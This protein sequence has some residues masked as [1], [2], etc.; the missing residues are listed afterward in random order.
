MLGFFCLDCAGCQTA[1]VSGGLPNFPDNPL[2]DFA[3]SPPPPLF[4]AQHLTKHYGDTDVV[5]DLSFEIAS[6]ECLGVVGPNG[7]GKT[8]TI[9]MCLGLTVPDA[10]S[11][12]A[13]ALSMPLDAPA[14]KAQLGVVT[15]LDT[16][17]PHFNCAEKLLVYGRYFG[18]KEA[19]IDWR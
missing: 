18:L 4:Q 16:L 15:Q 5:Q 6:D 11:V 7:A 8:N 10:G 14:I 9:R 1:R 13:L 3:P 19:E 17:N 2:H 12:T